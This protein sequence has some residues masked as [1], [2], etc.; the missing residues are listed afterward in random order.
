ML[1]L[2]P[3]LPWPDFFQSPPPPQQTKHEQI[4]IISC[5]SAVK[6]NFPCHTTP[7]PDYACLCSQYLWRISCYENYVSGPW[8]HADRAI[9]Q[10]DAH[11]TC[12]E[13]GSV[14]VDEVRKEH[15]Q[16][17]RQIGNFLSS[18]VGDVSSILS[19]KGVTVPT[20]VIE[21]VAGGV[22]NAL[23]TP[24]DLTSIAA[25]FTAISAA[26]DEN[27]TMTITKIGTSTSSSTWRAVSAS[28]SEGPASSSS[29]I[30]L[31]PSPSNPDSG[32]SAGLI[33]GVVVRAIAA[34]A[35][36]GIFIL[37]LLRHRR[38]NKYQPSS[39]LTD[40]ETSPII[41]SF[42][43]NGCVPQLN[44][45]SIIPTHTTLPTGTPTASASPEP[46]LHSPISPVSPV[47]PPEQ[48]LW[49]S[50]PSTFA[51]GTL[52]RYPSSVD[53]IP[54]HSR[55]YLDSKIPQSTEMPTSANSW[56]LDGRE[57]SPPGELSVAQKNQR[58]TSSGVQRQGQGQEHV[59]NYQ[60]GEEDH[61]QGEFIG[62]KPVERA[63]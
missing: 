20:T 56:E 53:N 24:V 19:S 18:I 51:G 60:P 13:A 15:A 58:N 38:K 21:S 10:G 23:P 22:V 40:K 39:P 7:T 17:K 43:S 27:G 46:V 33:A 12:R 57:I 34:L 52:P 25:M 4:A 30:S 2:L 9:T 59:T 45:S 28:S 44:T 37:L 62:N 26:G 50:S 6:S 49:I 61:L 32:P 8:A 35:L 29:V 41:S 11:N 16:R 63:W 5:L 31:L 55:Y 36:I 48:A 1:T 47:I 3:T 54:L 42:S 14:A